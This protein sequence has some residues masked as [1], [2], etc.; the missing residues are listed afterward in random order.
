[1][2]MP[3]LTLTLSE[4][5]MPYCGISRA[6]VQASTTVCCTPFTSLPNTR[7]WGT[8]GAGRKSPSFRLPYTCSKAR[9]Q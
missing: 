7:A 3:A 4:C 1:M 5:F 6:W 8:P 2:A 9:T